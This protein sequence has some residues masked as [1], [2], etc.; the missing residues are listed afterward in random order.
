MELYT[1]QFD[2][3]NKCVKDR[4]LGCGGVFIHRLKESDVVY[5]GLVLIFDLVSTFLL[6]C[7]FVVAY[8]NNY[9]YD[10]LYAANPKVYC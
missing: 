10:F 7:F 6:I 1:Y 8:V 9:F 4:G 5:N 2:Q 3:I